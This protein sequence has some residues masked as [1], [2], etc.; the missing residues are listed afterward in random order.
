M[1]PVTFDRPGCGKH[2]FTSRTEA[3]Q[4]ANKIRKGKAGGKHQR[5]YLCDDPTCVDGGYWHLTSTSSAYAEFYRVRD[6]ERRE[7]D[8]RKRSWLWPF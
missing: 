8:K 1:A 6:N 7:N 4:Y 2:R 3:K 5:P